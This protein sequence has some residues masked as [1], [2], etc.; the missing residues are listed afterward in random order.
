MERVPVSLDVSDPISHTINSLA[1]CT[2]KS[3]D[4]CCSE[5]DDEPKSFSVDVEAAEFADVGACMLFEGLLFVF[6]GGLFDE[7]LDAI[8]VTLDSALASALAGPVAKDLTGLLDALSDGSFGLVDVSFDF[9]EAPEVDAN[10]GILNGFVRFANPSVDLG[11]PFEGP[12][13]ASIG[14]ADARFGACRRESTTLLRG[15]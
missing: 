12:G 13:N 9:W 15:S 4:A 8:V 3:G 11:S 1:V 6:L 14:I 10:E 7:L 5:L 2:H